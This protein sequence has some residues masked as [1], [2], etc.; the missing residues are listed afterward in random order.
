[1]AITLNDC[2]E[3]L[4]KFSLE[5][6]DAGIAGG[7]LA[8]VNAYDLSGYP[9]ELQTTLQIYT[10]CYIV[11]ASG[12]RELRSRGANGKSQSF[13]DKDALKQLKKFIRSLDTDGVIDDLPP[14]S[15]IGVYFT[16]VNGS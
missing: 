9:A 2:A 15:D 13:R 7:I 5:V 4:D 3:Q 14:S 11:L 6:P 1:M 10:F 12:Q 16:V 8:K